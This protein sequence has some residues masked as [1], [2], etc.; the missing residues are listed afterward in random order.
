MNEV[1]KDL[2]QEN[3]RHTKCLQEPEIFKKI[4]EIRKVK[5][6]NNKVY[7]IRTDPTTKLE[8]MAQVLQRLI[9]KS[10]S[11]DS[12]NDLTGFEQSPNQ[13]LQQEGPS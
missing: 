7:L 6:E 12:S 5:E 2:N 9:C 4:N 13:L 1:I 3:N 11:L 8:C 10:R